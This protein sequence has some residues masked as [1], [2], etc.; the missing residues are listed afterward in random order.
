MEEYLSHTNSEPY[1]RQHMK[2]KLLEYLGDK[3]IITDINGKPKEVMFRTTAATILQEFHIKQNLDIEAEKINIIKAAA[4]LTK[5]DLKSIKT[6][7]ENYPEIDSDV[8]SNGLPWKCCLRKIYSLKM[9]GQAIIQAH[10][11][12]VVIAPLKIG[13]AVQLHHWQLWL[14]LSHRD[15]APPQPQNLPPTSAAVLYHSRTCIYR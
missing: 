5:N 6:T 12:R 1:G 9:S 15:L 14:A 3:I 13:L 8:E 11:P 4:K 2:T 10:G 7:N